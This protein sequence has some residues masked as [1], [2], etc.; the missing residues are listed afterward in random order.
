MTTNHG[1]NVVIPA[2]S[3]SKNELFNNFRDWRKVTEILKRF[4]RGFDGA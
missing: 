2:L 4:F 1:L 3:G